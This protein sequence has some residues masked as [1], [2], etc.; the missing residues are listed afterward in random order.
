[1]KTKS[2]IN[3]PIDTDILKN[4]HILNTLL[5]YITSIVN[6][7]LQN[8]VFPDSEKYAIVFPKIKDSTKPSDDPSN[9]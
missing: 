1:M 8:G 9:Y 4:S 5:P 7:S 6:K 3:D 2:C